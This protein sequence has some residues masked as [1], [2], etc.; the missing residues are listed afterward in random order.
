MVTRETPFKDTPHLEM[1]RAVIDDNARPPL[2][3]SCPEA[4]SELVSLCWHPIPSK[5]P[6]FADILAYLENLRA[7]YS[8]VC[9]VDGSGWAV[10]LML[11]VGGV[12]HGNTSWE[13]GG[14]S[15]G[16]GT[17]W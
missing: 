15:R 6:S 11:F 9:G 13:G 14:R 3:P 2:P 1:A 12:E 5:R 10:L 4:L 16:G 8:E 17:S 7:S